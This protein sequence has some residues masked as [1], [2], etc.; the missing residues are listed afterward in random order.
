MKDLEI[1]IQVRVENDEPL[2]KLLEEEGN[3][4][5]DDHQTDEYYTPCHRDFFATKPIDEWL[6]IR[7]S[8]K[9]SITY[10]NWHHGAD[11]KTTHADEYETVVSDAEQVRKI[12]KVLDL[13]PVITVYKYRRSWNYMDYEVSVDE[14]K[15]LGSFVELEYK[16]RGN[17]DPKKVN[18]EMIAFLKK[19]GVGKIERNFVGY[20]YLLLYGT[21]G[22]FE[23]V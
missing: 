20:P 10:K 2:I 3:P 7:E 14:I 16:G 18:D 5:L 17:V 15:G 9:H 13:K 21:E 4:V 22:Y 8:G 6:R 1:E 23:E 11:G 12:F 19:V